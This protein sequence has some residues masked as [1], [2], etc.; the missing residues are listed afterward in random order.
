VPF[1]AQLVGVPAGLP[2]GRGDE[3]L[4]LGRLIP[5]G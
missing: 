5:V 2:A 4:G 3:R 1:G